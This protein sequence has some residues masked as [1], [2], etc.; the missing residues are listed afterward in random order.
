MSCILYYSNFCEPS[1]KLLQTVSKTQNV[2]NIHFVCIDKRVKD[3]NGKVFIILQTGQKLLMPENVTRVP[4]LLLLNQNYK[5]IYGDDIYAHLR[6][7]VTQEIKQATKNNM[8]PMNFQDGFGSFGGFSGGIVSDN[9][10][11]LD[12]SDSELSVKGDGGL[13]QIHNYV[14]LNDSMNLSMKLPQ[15]D[16]DYKTD[17]LKE[18]EMS[19]EALQRR[20]EEELANISY[21]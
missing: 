5:V 1:K 15:D 8:E 13:R 11:F 18:G 9:F 16:F 4:A 19:V 2:T 21:K 7:Q 12:Q 3:S 10:S 20:R 17:K 14:T 6:P